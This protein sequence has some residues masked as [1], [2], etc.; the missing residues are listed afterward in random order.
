MSRFGTELVSSSF[1]VAACS[2]S[3]LCLGDIAEQ[4]GVT[5]AD[6]RVQSVNE[7]A[8]TGQQRWQKLANTGS[9]SPA[10]SFHFSVM[11]L[12]M[13]KESISFWLED[14]PPVFVP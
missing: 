1:C 2:G 8:K 14:C 6:E 5:R 9:N 13:Y 12:R 11:V 4:K 10:G 3:V 7:L